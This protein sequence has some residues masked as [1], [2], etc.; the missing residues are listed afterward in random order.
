[1][2]RNTIMLLMMAAALSITSCRDD[3]NQTNQT[4]G[5]GTT[6]EQI[7]YT[8]IKIAMPSVTGTRAAGINDHEF[9]DGTE[10]ENA[11][12]NLLILFYDK[13]RGVPVGVYNQEQ[14]QFSP[15]DNQQDD[16]EGKIQWNE[17]KTVPIK[18][19]RPGEIFYALAFL[20]YDATAWKMYEQSDLENLN[21]DNA[22]QRIVD[23]YAVQLGENAKTYFLMTNSGY[24]KTNGDYEYATEIKDF[25]FPTADEAKQSDA[26]TIYVERA[27]AR[28]DV[29]IDG[30]GIAKYDVYHG[31]KLYQLQFEPQQWGLTATEKEN[32][33]I[34]H[35]EKLSEYTPTKGYAQ[36]FSD[37]IDYQKHRTYWAETP[38]FN[39][40]IY[41]ETGLADMSKCQLNYA[42]F[43]ELSDWTKT[44]NIYSGS[45]YTFEHTFPAADFDEAVNPYAL[46]TSVV[47][48]GAYT[49]T[50]Q[51]GDNLFT[52][53]VKSFYIR[54]LGANK[55]IYLETE[56]ANELF[57][58]M[59]QEQTVICVKS[60]D[61]PEQY[62]PVRN[63]DLF[64][65]VNTEIF[66]YASGDQAPSSNAYTLQMRENVDLTTHE[67]YLKE[68]DAEKSSYTYTRIE[69][70][71]SI[72]AANIVLQKNVGSAYKYN[73]AKAYFYVPVLHYINSSSYPSGFTGDLAYQLPGDRTSQI[74]NKTGEFGIVRNHIY[75]LTI[76]KIEG[77]GYGDGGDGKPLPDPEEDKQHWFHAKLDVLSWHV[78]EFHTSL[79]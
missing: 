44:D 19:L 71:A 53:D 79:K 7:A 6:D 38:N 61:D 73:E 58:A 36:G 77:L 31:D 27:A 18:M 52:A 51:S 32:Y 68:Y 13:D 12:A 15:D 69:D 54:K 48:Y 42:A 67:L 35:S 41:P 45:T 5:F 56:T 43:D 20:N 49:A 16:V 65:I 34:K 63:E 40:Y 8:N 57:G 10:A 2:K 39:K 66:Y 29:K 21:M 17:A 75:K 72:K 14:W 4:P 30:D 3:N 59:L 62:S 33:L 1:M 22:Y 74:V 11:V 50:S 55:H 9:Q 46:P 60:E 64:N 26:I 37:W 25:I 47:I 76:D 70:E 78:I 28:V 23:T 24:F